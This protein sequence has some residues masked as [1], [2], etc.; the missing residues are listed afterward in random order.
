MSSNAINPQKQ[1]SHNAALKRIREA[2]GYKNTVLPKPNTYLNITNRS[3]PI[4][5]SFHLPPLTMSSSNYRKANPGLYN[6]GR[7]SHKK[8]KR[9]RRTRSKRS[10]KN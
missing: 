10:R 1:N 9:S 3:R 8:S 5:S 6:G 2:R 7:R 4:S